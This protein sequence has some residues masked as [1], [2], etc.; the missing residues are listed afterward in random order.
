MRP[1]EG[2]V[3][4]WQKAKIVSVIPSKGVYKLLLVFQKKI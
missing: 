2:E 4:R 1:V 3:R